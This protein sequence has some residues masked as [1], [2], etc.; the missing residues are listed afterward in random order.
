VAKRTRVKTVANRP[1]A[2]PATSRPG[3][4]RPSTPRAVSAPLAP[5]QPMQSQVDAAALI[6]TDRGMTG[7]TEAVADGGAIA[8]STPG[9]VKVKPN[10]LL[11]AK[12]ATEYVYVGQDLRRIAIV[13]ASLFGILLLLWIVL[14]VL[15]L[16]GLY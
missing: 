5:A 8:R 6:R 4:P 16:S 12:A 2:R 9:R 14:V 1:G 7:A 10:S 13:G 15:G 3:G 11:A